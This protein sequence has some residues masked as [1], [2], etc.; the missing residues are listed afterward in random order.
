[1]RGGSAY[2]DPGSPLYQGGN[3]YAFTAKKK[4]PPLEEVYNISKKIN[5]KAMPLKD[6]WLRNHH[7]L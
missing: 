5:S 1:V 2:T 6:F 4:P 7:L 3:I